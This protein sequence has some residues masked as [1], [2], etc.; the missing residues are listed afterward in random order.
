M[1]IRNSNAFAGLTIMVL[2]VILFMAYWTMMPAHGIIYNKLTNSSNYVGYVTE[3]T[4]E[5]A[6][7]YWDV[8]DSA[9]Q[10]QS[11]RALGL[12]SYTRK[13]WL[14]VPFIFVVGLIIWLIIVSV[15]RDPQQY[16]LR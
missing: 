9:C 15:K 3:S 5:R 11:D 1:R 8:D 10:I 4:C 2:I 6:G 7:G 12:I 16:Y 13:I 14:I